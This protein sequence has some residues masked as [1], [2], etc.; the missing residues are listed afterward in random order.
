[1]LLNNEQKPV[2]FAQKRVLLCFFQVFSV[3]DRG[4]SFWSTFLSDKN[5]LYFQLC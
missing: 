2:M 4:F 5:R 3:I 1:M